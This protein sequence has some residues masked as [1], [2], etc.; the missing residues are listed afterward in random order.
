MLIKNIRLRDRE[1]IWDILV[2]DGIISKID[3]DIDAQGY[4][5]IDGRGKLAMEPFVEPHIHLDT[6]MSAGE[7]RWNMSG[8]LFEGIECWSE[9]K[10]MLSIE[11][12]K[13][14]AKKAL[15]WQIA[16]GIQ[17]VRTHCDVTDPE[18]TALKALLEVREEMNE[19]VE[20]LIVAFPQEGIL[21]YKGGLE[22]LEK[23]LVTGADVVGAIPHF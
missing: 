14:R 23:A 18:L 15:E 16:N 20:I 7:P 4:Q 22:L 13:R 2:K 1:G 12:V 11:D 17:F 8:T 3:R 21:S 5:V 6:T 9:R 10:E 19:F